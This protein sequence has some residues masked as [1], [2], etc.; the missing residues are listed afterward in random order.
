MESNLDKYKGRLTA[1]VEVGH[2]LL[3]DLAEKTGPN[4]TPNAGTKFSREYEMWYT[5]A[6]EVVRQLI[7]NRLNEF[8]LQYRQ[9]GK[10]KD[11]TSDNYGVA[12]FM[13]GMTATDRQGQEIFDSTS[14]A[15]M[16]FQQQVKILQAARIRFESVLMDIRG[17]VQADLFDSELSVANELLKKGFLRA[18]GAVAGVVLESHLAEICKQ[19]SVKTKNNPHISDLNDALKSVEIIDMAKWRYTQ[20]LGD[21]RNLCDHKKDKEPT[22]AEVDEL[23][24]GVKKVSKTIF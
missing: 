23:I 21:L 12:D 24:E 14:V 9:S 16:R 5:E 7:P 19:H 13:L 6:L 17:L 3:S 18:A 20:H 8:E 11:V 4:P 22:H 15:L 10:R 2:N 1:L